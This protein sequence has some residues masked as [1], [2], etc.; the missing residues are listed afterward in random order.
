MNE[1]QPILNNSNYPSSPNLSNTEYP[2][3]N[4]SG[5]NSSFPPTSPKKSSHTKILIAVIVLILASAGLAVGVYLSQ[6]NQETRKE[7][8]S[9][10][11]WHCKSPKGLIVVGESAPGQPGTANYKPASSNP[12]DASAYYD[13]SAGET[14]RFSSLIQNTTD[15][16]INDQYQFTTSKIIESPKGT[17][18][19]EN[20]PLGELELGRNHSSSGDVQVLTY[21]SGYQPFSVGANQTTT[22]TGQWTPTNQDCGLY[23]ID[24]GVAD[25]PSTD[26]SCQQPFPRD[27]VVGAGFIRVS[28]CETTSTPSPTPF[29][30]L[31]CGDSC[32]TTEECRTI[33]SS[34]P[35]LYYCDETRN[36]CVLEACLTE[37]CTCSEST[38]TPTPTPQETPTS[39]A[40]ACGETCDD[41]NLCPEG[42]TCE[43][44]GDEA[45][46]I[47]VVEA[48]MGASCT[49]SE[50]TPT[51]TTTPEETPAPE[52][53]ISPS[54][55]SP[56]PAL[57]Q[58]GN[59]LP[60]I[61]L[62]MLGLG[63][64]LAGT[65]FLVF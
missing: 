13:V 35:N 40:R 64:L 50:S 14:V 41:S 16:E 30:K 33:D 44:R 54:S 39:E 26:N 49:C 4:T 8:G 59:S 10:G 58:A 55:P 37:S 47:C 9:I 22:I 27:E 2:P 12:E 19:Y 20:S 60:T 63:I 48:C 21:D 1:N 31:E 42:L 15:S 28:N 3:L 38:P 34:N 17:K 61:G 46:S 23:Q 51:P 24:L 7:A 43:D 25:F 57:P 45:G 18:V 36:I 52:A 6:Q 56:I 5:V 11:Q 32:T 65:L 29:A 53:T 62:A